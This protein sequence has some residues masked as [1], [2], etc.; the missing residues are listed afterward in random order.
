MNVSIPTRK[1]QL[2][3]RQTLSAYLELCKPKVVA[4]M[5]ITSTVGMLLATTDGI[6]WHILLFGNLGIALA[7]G[8]AAVIN[9]F[10]D[11]RIDLLM[12]RTQ[13]RPL[14]SGKVSVNSSLVFAGILAILA[15]IILL[16]FT[17]VLVTVLT[18]L[19]L[20]VY[21]GI[22][23]YYLKQATSQNIVIGGIAGATPPLLGWTAVTGHITVAGLV[24][25]LIIFV[26]TPPHFWA[27]AIYR[28]E[29]Y[30][31]ANVP[32]LPITHG[33]PYTKQHILLY[34]LLLAATTLLPVVIGLAGWLYLCSITLLNGRF[35]YWAVRLYRSADKNN[36]FKLF[37][38]SILY[39]LLL[40]IALLLDHYLAW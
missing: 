40:F 16:A 21:A 31:K 3:W 22:Y 9:H 13:H 24:L 33:I 29:D 15:L 32:M 27:L 2:T 6:P 7:A 8:A 1:H 37:K 18:F 5:I 30:R 38:F 4:L 12:Q 14:V 25:L 28:V 36:G 17:N 23:T 11:S 39:L 19:S 26:W 35:I 34:T 20:I 10:A